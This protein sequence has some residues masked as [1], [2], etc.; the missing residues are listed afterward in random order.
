[1]RTYADHTHWKR[2]Q[3]FFPERARIT[4][5]NAPVE[6]AWAWRE[7]T[8]HLDRYE[9]ADA[10]VKVILLHGAGANG[11]IMGA[12]GT[13]L[14]RHGYAAVAPDLPGYG[15]TDCPAS[16]VHSEA[17]VD[18]VSDLVDAEIARDGL[19]VVLFGAS[20][21]GMLTYQVAC[22]NPAVSGIIATTLADPSDP[23]TGPQLA[24][25]PALARV[26]GFFLNALSWVLDPIP[27]PIRW[28]SKMNHISNQPEM[29]RALIAD[30]TSA[31]SVVPLRFLR[32]LMSTRPA[33][34]PEEFDVCP[35]LL[36]HPERDFM[37]PIAMSEAFYERLSGDKTYVILEG[38]GHMPL[39]QPGI[40]QLEEAVLSFLG[41][42]T[43]NGALARRITAT[44]RR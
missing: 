14:R 8:M 2:Y 28:V 31:G 3:P 12:F 11:R 42:F 23:A 26:G 9:A 43:A 4:D 34:Q 10:Q 18:A 13:L 35:V 24:V 39:E 27:V 37:T 32:T 25:F 16:L 6:E 20:L 21:G 29:V 30:P 1:M 17:W 7:A 38:A 33:M 44:R 40:D 41:R 22:K 19:P 5:A 15:L 36:V